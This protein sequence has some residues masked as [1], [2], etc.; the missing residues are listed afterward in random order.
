MID[1]LQE[2]VARLKAKNSKF[3][4]VLQWIALVAALATGLPDLMDF[5]GITLPES[6][7]VLQSKIVAIASTVVFVLAQ[8]DVDPAVIKTEAQAKVVDTQ[9]KLLPFSE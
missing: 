7:T 5:F 9:D 6:L 1:F 2:L 8:L 4:K 3:F